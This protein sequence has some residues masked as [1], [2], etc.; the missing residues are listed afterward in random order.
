[1]DDLSPYEPVAPNRHPD[2]FRLASISSGIAGLILSL[3]ILT[4]SGFLIWWETFFSREAE[5]EVDDN[6]AVVWRACVYLLLWILPASS[7]WKI[8]SVKFH[9]GSG[10]SRTDLSYWFS[11]SLILP[12][13]FQLSKLALSSQATGCPWFYWV[14]LVLR[15]HYHGRGDLSI[16]HNYNR[17]VE[18]LRLD[19]DFCP[20]YS[21]LKFLFFFFFI[22]LRQKIS[23][24]CS[25]LLS[26][27]KS[28]TYQQWR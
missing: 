23:R 24:G 14:K 5:V 10:L 21:R 22:Q 28:N 7:P 25:L 4:L 16:K 1:M 9:M 26:V 13:V 27:A 20:G 2:A 17:K 18:K 3:N 19:T 15:G 8:H 6:S 12:L 11:F